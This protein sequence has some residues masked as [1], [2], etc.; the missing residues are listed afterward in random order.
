VGARGVYRGA[1]GFRRFLDSFWDEFDEPNIETRDLIEAGN[2]VL[3][4]ATFQGRGKQSGAETSWDLWQV[5]T[6]RDG[7]V[8]RGQGFTSKE[9]ALEAAGLRE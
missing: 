6:L 3:T 9:E 4:S 2:Q 7:K 1:E 8:V 5:W